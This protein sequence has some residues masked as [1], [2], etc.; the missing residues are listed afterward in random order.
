MVGYIFWEAGEFNGVK[1]A[2]PCTILISDTEIAAAD[3]TQKL[4]SLSVTV[5]GKTYN[6]D[7]L[8]KGSTVVLAK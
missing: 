8:Y 4:T 6:F 3:P 7:G 1:A 2:K 5:D